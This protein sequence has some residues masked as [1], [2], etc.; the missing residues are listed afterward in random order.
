[1]SFIKREADYAIRIAAFLAGKKDKVKIDY[2]CEKLYLNKPIVI[3]IIHKLSKCGIIVTETGRYGGVAISP[4]AFDL[5]LMDILHCIGFVNSINICVDQPEKCLLNPICN[6][7]TFFKK[8]QDDVEEKL[9]GAK[10]KDFL[11]DE[12][13]LKNVQEVK[14]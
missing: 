12:E 8:L 14:L 4:H 5:S 9:K 2:I 6:I 10:L 11:F 13:N 7:T 3:K 1:M